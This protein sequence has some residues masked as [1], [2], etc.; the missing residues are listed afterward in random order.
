MVGCRL[1]RGAWTHATC[2]IRPP[3]ST[4]RAIRNGD[5]PGRFLRKDEKTGKWMEIDDKKAAEKCS[6]ALREKTDQEQDVQI[7]AASMG[8]LLAHQSSYMAGTAALVMG[9][10]MSTSADVAAAKA[11]GESETKEQVKQEGTFNHI[12]DTE[13]LFEAAPL[14]GVEAAVK[15]DV[16]QG[17]EGASSVEDYSAKIDGV[18]ADPSADASDA[19]ME[20]QQ[21]ESDSLLEAEV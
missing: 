15:E 11:A 14:P 1:A 9:N 7:M 2:C 10:L 19:P 4:V 13:A 18:H 6:Q 20:Q 3:S 17:T 16:G 21:L 12:A 8:A 5:P